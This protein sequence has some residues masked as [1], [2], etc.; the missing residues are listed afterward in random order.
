MLKK[1]KVDGW[2]P[3][4]LVVE[5]SR[6]QY[7]HSRRF[8]IGHLHNTIEAKIHTCSHKCATQQ[9]TQQQDFHTNMPILQDTK[10]HLQTMKAMHLLSALQSNTMTFV[11]DPF[12]QAFLS[13]SSFHSG[14]TTCTVSRQ[15]KCWLNGHT[16][17]LLF[18]VMM[19]NSKKPHCCCYIQNNHHTSIW[20]MKLDLVHLSLVY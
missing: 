4:V 9:H 8:S 13:T 17:N 3:H 6:K 19:P 12:L 18:G 16:C 15:T 11:L 7:N 10:E 14:L 1:C 5:M 2:L 20:H